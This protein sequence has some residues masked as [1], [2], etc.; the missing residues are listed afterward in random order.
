MEMSKY[1]VIGLCLFL[2]TGLFAQNA[3]L[4]E[5]VNVRSPLH[6]WADQNGDGELDAHE[7]Q[8]F[9]K[10]VTSFFEP[11]RV[12]TQFDR[13]FDH[14]EN[15]RIDQ[16]EVG[17]VREEVFRPLLYQLYV[18]YPDAARL[19]DFDGNTSIDPHEVELLYDFLFYDPAL[20]KPRVVNSPL[21]EILDRNNNNRVERAEIKTAYKLI[22][23]ATFLMPFDFE[24]NDTF[25]GPI[26]VESWLMI[27]GDTNNNNLLEEQEFTILQDSMSEPHP[28]QTKVDEILDFNKNG[29]VESHEIRQAQRKEE[30]SRKKREEMTR[31]R[32]RT[33]IDRHL[34]LNQDNFVDKVEIQE[35]VSM[36][37]SGPQQY[38][39][40]WPVHELIDMNDDRYVSDDELRHFVDDVIIPHPVEGNSVI[41]K[42]SDINRDGFVDPEEIGI[43]FGQTGQ[44]EIPPIVELVKMAAGEFANESARG[45]L[46]EE[47][48]Q[49]EDVPDYIQK[50]L[51]SMKDSNV[52]VAGI[53]AVTSNLDEETVNGLVIFIENAFVNVGTATVVDRQNVESILDEHEFQLS[54]LVNSQT[55]VRIGELLS[56]QYLVVGNISYVGENYYLQ[57]KVISCEKGEVIG[58]SV[59]QSL[60]ADGFYDMTNEAVYNLF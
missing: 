30:A 25:E 15:R 40:K 18:L 5:S 42:E 27:I 12:K 8:L 26:Q 43:A 14:N 53:T 52:A 11:H 31:V 37:L 16:D 57:V 6:G 58:S 54:D 23:T 17:F 13:F 21:D 56:A 24:E 28:I 39:T 59:S 50:K 48:D 36:I 20:K 29:I 44:A 49:P 45:L 35:I 1:I 51:T 9:S 34:D 7:F 3:G 46:P 32:P 60:G 41:D 4:P 22:V 33:F 47:P 2:H 19:V 10:I 38:E 55:A